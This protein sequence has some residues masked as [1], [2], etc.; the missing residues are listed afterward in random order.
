[1]SCHVQLDMNEVHWFKFIDVNLLWNRNFF[2]FAIQVIASILLNYA[3]SRNPS[4]ARTHAQ[5][6]PGA[7]RA[8]QL[9]SVLA[10][11]YSVS[12]QNLNTPNPISLVMP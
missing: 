6:D 9:R 4:C 1:M 10:R 8:T 2:F 3:R 12:I 11:V 5:I 7:Q